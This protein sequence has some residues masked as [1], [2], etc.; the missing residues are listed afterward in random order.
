MLSP[1]SGIYQRAKFDPRPSLVGGKEERST[2]WKGLGEPV[3]E[4]SISK[5]SRKVERTAPMSRGFS[6]FSE[7]RVLP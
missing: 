4:P 1:L 7:P 6:Q 2:V 5:A 3:E